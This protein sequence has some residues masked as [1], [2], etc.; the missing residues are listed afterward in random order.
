MFFQAM[1]PRLLSWPPH[2]FLLVT[3]TSLHHPGLPLALSAGPFHFR[4]APYPLAPFIPVC[5]L[6]LEDVEHTAH[7]SYTSYTLLS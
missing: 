4:P 3:H 5:P 7:T 2:S 1:L 6:A